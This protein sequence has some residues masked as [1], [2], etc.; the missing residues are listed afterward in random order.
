M[1]QNEE[2][3]VLSWILNDETG[4]VHDK[5]KLKMAFQSFEMLSNV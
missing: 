2:K 1:Q 4:D 5:Q 3:E